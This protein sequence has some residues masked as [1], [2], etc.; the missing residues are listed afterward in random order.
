MKQNG[1]KPWYVRPALGLVGLGFLSLGLMPL[2]KGGFFYQ[3][4][5]GGA[6]YAPLV[7]LVGVFVLYMA[8]FGWRR[9]ESRNA[10]KDS[11]EGKIIERMSASR[12]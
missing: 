11:N 7:V 6:A 3:T 5:W 2:L 10:D 9:L 12:E 4:Y 8:T 1:S